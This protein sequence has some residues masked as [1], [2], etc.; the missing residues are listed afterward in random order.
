[1]EKAKKVN[2]TVQKNGKKKVL[3]NPIHVKAFKE[4]GWTVV[5]PP[6]Q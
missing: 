6:A 3:T 4:A 5:T 1:M 2:V